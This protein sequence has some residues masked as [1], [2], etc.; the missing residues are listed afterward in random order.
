MAL[1]ELGGKDA[2]GVT[3]AYVQFFLTFAPFPPVLLGVPFSLAADLE[4]STVYDEGHGTIS[5][6]IDASV[7]VDRS[8]TDV[9]RL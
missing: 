8:I 6:G 9:C 3:H 1:R 2:T 5:E 4:T 7:N